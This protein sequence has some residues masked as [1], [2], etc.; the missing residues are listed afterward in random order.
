MSVKI[1]DLSSSFVDIYIAARVCF[2][3]S[4]VISWFQ[5]VMDIVV[6]ELVAEKY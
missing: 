5:G 1:S 2:E 4:L 6:G 3:S